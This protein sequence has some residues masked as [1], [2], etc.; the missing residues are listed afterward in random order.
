MIIF[1]KC[2]HTKKFTSHKSILVTNSIKS[3]AILKISIKF[4]FCSHAA[5]AFII[6]K[7]IERCHINNTEKAEKAWPRIAYDCMSRCLYMYDSVPEFSERFHKV[8]VATGLI[9]SIEL[10]VQW[11]IENVRSFY[12]RN[13]WLDWMFLSYYDHKNSLLRASLKNFIYKYSWCSR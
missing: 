11:H 5:T 6:T 10:I 7:T 9:C 4:H 2:H 1:Q 13:S 3:E 12:Y 8:G